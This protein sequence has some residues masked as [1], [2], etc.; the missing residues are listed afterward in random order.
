[1]TDKLNS[2]VHEDPRAWQDKIFKKYPELFAD[3]TK[4]MSQTAMCWGIDTGAGWSKIIDRVCAQLMLIRKA[5]GIK[6][7]FSQVKE[8]YG[9]IRLY[10]TNEDWC[11]GRPAPC[12]GNLIKAYNAFQWKVYNWKHRVRSTYYAVK[13]ELFP[14]AAA[15]RRERNNTWNDIIDACIDDAERRSAHTCE[16]CGA[17]GKM[18]KGGWVMVRCAKHWEGPGTYEDP[19]RVEDDDELGAPQPEETHEVG[20]A[21]NS[22]N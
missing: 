12:A 9:T 20:K 17:D 1:M 8:K 22:V 21:D 15:A 4:P 18:N 19:D 10:L 2:N 3:R 14:E 6:M 7:V 11:P 16:E 13:C 5:S